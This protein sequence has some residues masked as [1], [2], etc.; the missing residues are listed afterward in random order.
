MNDTTEQAIHT[1]SFK[2]LKAAYQ[3]K[4]LTPSEVIKYYLDN[5]KKFAHLNNF[6]TVCEE[7]AIAAAKISDERYAN[8]TARA[9]EGMP[10]S[11]KDLFCTKGIRTTAGSKMLE[12]FI[13]EYESEVSRLALEAGCINVGKCNMDEFAMGAS[14]K[15]SAFGYAI[16]PWQDKANNPCTP[17]G[18]SG[19]STSSVA[20]YQCLF[21]L[22]S[23]TGGSIRQP[24]AFCGVVGIRPTY[25]RC[26]RRGMIAFSSSL[27]QA[28]TIARDVSSAAALLEVIIGYDQY[29]STSSQMPKVNFTNVNSDI[30]GM[31]VGLINNTMFIKD[32]SILKSLEDTAKK[33]QEKGA[34]VEEV[35]IPFFEEALS[36]YYVLTPCEAA[37]NLARY[38]GI[39]YGTPGS[40]S[41]YYERCMSARELFGDEVKRRILIGTYFSSSDMYEKYFAQAWKV[42][43][44]LKAEFEKAFAKYDVLL[45]PTTPHT[46]FPLDEK[47]DPIDMY[48]EDYFTCPV[49]IGECCGI[50]VPVGLAVNGL[51]IG[52]QIVAP[53][54][55]EDLLVKFGLSIEESANFKSLALSDI[56]K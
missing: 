55:R 4:T 38:D 34:I 48:Y 11:I 32:S 29:D 43:K 5:I 12:N 8:G 17:G 24:A 18:S 52:M 21:S 14:N 44:L 46:A 51:P 16:N 19:G 40:G 13:P 45:S 1:L 36:V 23:D 22:G 28:G 41:T 56:K 53:A 25:G 30:K 47:K 31:K 35:N 2:Q 33:L 3:A 42:R 6:I 39:R 15:Y 7:D 49:N 37:S 27:D 10:L 50:S 9:L 26:S 54:F 20:A